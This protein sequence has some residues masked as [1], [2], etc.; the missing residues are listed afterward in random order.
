MMTSDLETC[1]WNNMIASLSLE[2]W[3]YIRWLPEWADHQTNIQIKFHHIIKNATNSYS[4]FWYLCWTIKQHQSMEHSMCSWL[5]PSQTT[6]NHQSIKAGMNQTGHGQ[7]M[8][9]LTIAVLTGSENPCFLL[10][11]VAL[12]KSIADSSSPLRSSFWNVFQQKSKCYSA[13]IRNVIQRGSNGKVSREKFSQWQKC[14]LCSAW[15]Q[16]SDCTR[17]FLDSSCSTHRFPTKKH[18]VS[19]I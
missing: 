3:F 17:L 19:M 14:V 4:K 8:E 10:L 1:N 5:A 6:S 2:W 11:W 15:N 7:S 12:N 13:R 18:T 16:F 9:W